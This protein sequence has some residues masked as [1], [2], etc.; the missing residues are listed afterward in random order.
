M[1]AGSALLDR[2][3]VNTCDAGKITS[4]ENIERLRTLELMRFLRICILITVPI[5]LPLEL[6]GCNIIN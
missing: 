4:P 1:W 5:T 2:R 3:N 6:I